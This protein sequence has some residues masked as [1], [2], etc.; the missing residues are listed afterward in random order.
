M[1][2]LVRFLSLVVV[3]AALGW[4]GLWWYAESRLALAVDQAAARLHAAGWTVSHGAVTRGTS[5]FV[6]DVRVADLRLTPP[7]ADGPAP[8]LEIPAVDLV[9]HPAAPLTLDL[10]FATVWRM[11]L[12]GGPSF[13]LR[14]GNIAA[15]DRFDLA[16]L[17]H[18]AP[19]P[20]RAGAFHAT[21]LRVDSEN[22]NF[23]LVSIAAI[24]ASGTRNPDAGP[25][26]MAATLHE[27]LRGLALSPLFVTLGN[28]PFGGKLTALSVDLALSGPAAAL[29]ARL[30]LPPGARW[31][32]PGAAANLPA[33][34]RQLGPALHR[35]AQGGGH[36]TYDF[37][38][39]VGPLD[40]HGTG[41][42][43]F[44]AGTQP[45]GRLHLVADGL[46]AALGALSTHYPSLTG[47]I[48]ALTTAAAPYFTRGPKGGQRL[49][50]DFVLAHGAVSANGTKLTTVPPLV[51]PASPQAVPGK[52][53]PKG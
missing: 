21:D 39:T 51:W 38:L 45:K 27:S 43:G 12:E 36:G 5:P 25:D 9:V 22:T 13:T 44:D 16:D 42:F 53:A 30:T 48:S 10:G 4:L 24:D 49:A 14:F 33:L 6:A 7:V 31:L 17:L 41:S 35:W 8:T 11:A 52:A 28:L 15:D 20:L 2:R 32:A 50:V 1:R 3:L 26:S 46:G 19:D 23:T 47:D 40:A 37:G 34:W 18:H 29:P